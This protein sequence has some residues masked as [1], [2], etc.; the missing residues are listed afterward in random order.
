M[1]AWPISPRDNPHAT[2][3][4]GL[5]KSASSFAFNRH[6]KIEGGATIEPNYE[7]MKLARQDFINALDEVHPAFGGLPLPCPWLPLNDERMDGEC[8]HTN[9]HHGGSLR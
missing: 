4:A 2:A 6:V 9:S 7:H 8:A 3:A 5:V 1:F